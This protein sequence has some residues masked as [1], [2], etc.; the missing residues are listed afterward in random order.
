MTNSVRLHAL[1]PTAVNIELKDISDTRKS[2]VV[3]LD[4]TEVEAE[5]RAVIEEIAKVA[6]VPGF[7]PGRAP[8]DLIAKRFGKEVLDEFKKK[9]V[10]R[11]YRN[12][13]EK[14]KLEVAGVVKVEEGRIEPGLS[15]AV[16]FTLDVHPPIEL[17]EYLG[18]PT[19]VQPT[20]ATEAEVDA[21]VENLRQ[22]RADFKVV[23]RAAQ[24]G[25][26][27]KLAYQGTIEGKPIADLPPEKQ[28][29]GQ[30]PQT[31]EEVEGEQE[32]L[33]PGLGR[34]LAGLK[35]GDK[36][37]VAVTFPLNFAAVPELAGKSASYA[38]EVQ[39][40]RTRVLP[41][42]DASRTLRLILHICAP[43]VSTWRWR[44]CGAMST[45]DSCDNSQ[46]VNSDDCPQSSHST[47]NTHTSH[48]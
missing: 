11:A 17:P 1:F 13:L 16:T 5:H 23:D 32:G 43:P 18:L 21:V 37:D 33:I 15:S 25:D 45:C 10:N 28:V 38:V 41:E 34:Q 36:K 12:G 27:V 39:E 24:K 26:Y 7:R 40:V 47:V 42:L 46:H 20:E 2:L 48:S 22:E 4:V 6:R 35:A 30:V 19:S 9:V 31:W 14:A 8:A 29:Y 44:E 3:T